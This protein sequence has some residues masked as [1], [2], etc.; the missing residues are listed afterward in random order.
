ME[1]KYFSEKIAK[2]VF[3]IFAI[4]AIVAVCSITV[5]MIG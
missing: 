5:Y 2:G 1:K 4:V 3:T